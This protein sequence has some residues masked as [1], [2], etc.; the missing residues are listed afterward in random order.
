M[1][2]SP[3]HL[4]QLERTHIRIGLK[5]RIDQLADLAQQA[6]DD[7]N[8]GTARSLEATALD[9]IALLNRLPR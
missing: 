7:E 2:T 8:H 5:L 1:A 3:I 4:S 6:R 9:A